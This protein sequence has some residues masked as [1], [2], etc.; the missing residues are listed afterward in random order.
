MPCIRYES[1]VD[2]RYESIIDVRT[3]F[4][5]APTSDNFWTEICLT[6]RTSYGLGQ[7]SV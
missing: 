2:V 7:I 4:G 3:I 5:H 1:V 6:S